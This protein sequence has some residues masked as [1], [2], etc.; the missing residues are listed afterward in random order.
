M[1]KSMTGFGRAEQQNGSLACKVE[2]RSVNSRFIEINTRLPKFLNAL[3]LPLKKKV[4]SRCARG[5]F[6]VFVYLEKSDGGSA[7]QVIKPNLTLASQYLE[8]FNSLKKDLGLAG[9]LP[10]EALMGIKDII[11]SETPTLDEE[12]ESMILETLNEALTSLITMRSDEGANLE[13]DLRHLMAGIGKR[14]E[15]IKVDQ[16][17]ILELYKTRLREK[18]QALGD[19]VEIDESRL[20]QEIAIMA[21]RSDI[22]EEITRLESHLAQV[23]EMLKSE[24]P[25]GRKLEFITQEINRETNTIGSKSAGTAISQSVIEMKSALEK[26]REQLQN[27]E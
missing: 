7:D 9:E 3:E 18:I 21:D 15:A 27:I 6:D 1:L 5:S 24:E 19:T 23:S 22:T 26:I 17:Q 12:Q 16:P 10:I 20:A 4:K 8:A 11:T 2:I 13:K 25:I 14:L